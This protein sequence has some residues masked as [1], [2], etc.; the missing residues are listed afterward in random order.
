[1]N[2]RII[3]SVFL[4]ALIFA[5]VFTACSTDGGDKENTR[6]TQVEPDK[7]PGDTTSD[8]SKDDLPDMD[9]GG[10]AFRVLEWPDAGGEHTNI[11]PESQNGDILNDSI[12]K[13][14]SRVEARLNIGFKQV[15]DGTYADAPDLVKKSVQTGDD[16]YDLALVIDRDAM[17]LAME[18]K[19]FYSVNELPNIN[20]EKPYW[21][22]YLNDALSI[23]RTLYFAYGANMLSIMDYMT[24][25]VYNKKIMQNEGITENIY[26]LVRR[27]KWTMEKMYELGRTA[28]RDLDG[29]GK[30]TKTDQYG[31]V[32]RHD[33]YYPSF[34]YA[35]KIPLVAKDAD[36]L[37][38]FN[39][40]GNSRLF[41]IFEKQYEYATSGIEF[42]TLDFE[43]I[44]SMFADGRAL[45]AG[46]SMYR[47]Q[48]LR[49]MDTDYGIVPYP[50]YDEQ[51][52]GT[53]YIARIISGIPLVVPATNQDTAMAS[54]VMEALACEYYFNVIPSYYGLVVQ[55]KA[56]RD[57]ESREMLDMF[58]ANKFLDL[59]ETVWMMYG[60]VPYSQLL[61]KKSN[62]FASKTESLEETFKDVIEQSINAFR[63]VK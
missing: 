58:I 35:N 23:D 16:A 39:V 14:N 51:P 63:E 43:A 48:S 33:Y 60:R 3:L 57:D 25:L 5:F 38:Y 31:M 40:P 59:G 45:F 28:T 49:G 9:F 34:W 11:V 20:L 42:E 52:A 41:D 7:N 54:A 13:A 12:Y 62:E 19:Y 30:M 44:D 24:F 32:F 15:V 53:P 61:W 37:P 50:T 36:D 17:N 21:D 27:G 22:K 29:D 1:M 10:Y 6:D 56:T 26:D 55:E 47:V 46:T 4:F 2:K 18:S 8:V